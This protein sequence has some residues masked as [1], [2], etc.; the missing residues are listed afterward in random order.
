MT[1]MIY[2]MAV[3]LL[4]SCVSIGPQ[5]ANNDFSLPDSVDAANIHKSEKVVPFVEVSQEA[6]TGLKESWNV[7]PGVVVFDYDRDGDS[8]FYVTNAYGFSNW[9]YNNSGDGNFTNVA[10]EAGADLRDSHGT[11]VVACDVDND[12]FQDLY[13]GGQGS[14]IDRLD[15]RSPAE[16][17]QNRDRLLLNN[18][19]GTFSDITE[20]AFSTSVNMRSAMSVA[21]AD[22]DNDGWLD[23]FVGNL[24]E[25]DFRGMSVPYLNGQHNVLYRNNGNNTFT[26][27]AAS[28]GVQGPQ[29]WMRELDGTPVMYEDEV[30]GESFEAYDPNL[31]DDLG[32]RVGDPSGQTQ[33]VTFFDYDSDGDPDLWVA[34]DGDRLHVYRNDSTPGSVKYTRVSR[35]MGVDQVGAWMGFAVGDYDGDSDLDIFITNVGYHP[36]LG[37]APGTPMPYCAY[38]ERMNWGTCL[39][40]LLR[41]DGVGEVPGLGLVGK[42]YDVAP[43]TDVIPS[44]LMPPP[45]LEAYNIDPSQNVPTGLSAYDFGFGATFFD[46]D[47]DMDQD[48]YWLG[49]T[50]DRGEAPGG[51]VFPSAGRMLRNN[52]RG[53]FEDITVR[54]H[55]LD[56]DRVRY[57]HIDPEDPEKNVALH[58]AH[59]EFHE[60]GKGVV[61]GDLNGDGY[62]D[63]I[64]TNSKGSLWDDSR[65]VTFSEAGGPLFVWMN[66][67]GDNN[68]LSVRLKGRMAIDGTGSNADGIG[69]RVYVTAGGL[70]QVREVQ[71]GSSYLSMDSI[72]SEFGL[73]SISK[74]EE[75]KVVWPSGHIQLFTDVSVNQVMLVEESTKK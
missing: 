72:D 48:L 19:D 28:A 31:V 18:G 36:R 44:A 4:A 57:K 47:N 37:E 51:D 1:V 71:A 3:I 64:A 34:N 10:V 75:V 41:N 27:V 59:P 40:Y 14:L 45:S 38:H 67:G 6:L 9:L 55:L 50:I 74:V 30:T 63:L 58:R 54:A 62:L 29:V 32:N 35:A 24:G 21:C 61:H 22:V 16:G 8:D 70:T 17:D 66:P 13:V 5:E 25:A 43:S 39:H 52:G 7:R 2:F 26:D 33:A 12:G 20:A 73:A 65:K 69:A 60:N 11:G 23:I 53:T 56:I 68:W 42:F 46:F 49:S 15:F